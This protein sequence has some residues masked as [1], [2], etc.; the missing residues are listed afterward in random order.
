MAR[1]VSGFNT[2]FEGFQLFQ[3]QN[4]A[5]VY[6][7]AFGGPVSCFTGYHG[8]KQEFIM[9]VVTHTESPRKSQSRS[10]DVIL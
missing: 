8:W 7:Q 9:N 4:E 10:R 3:V 5:R 6:I 2:S 1:G